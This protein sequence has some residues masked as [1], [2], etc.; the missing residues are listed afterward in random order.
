MALTGAGALEW[1]LGSQ[2][3]KGTMPDFAANPTKVKMN[4]ANIM[5]GESVLAM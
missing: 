5:A 3:W 2:A 1:A 4:A